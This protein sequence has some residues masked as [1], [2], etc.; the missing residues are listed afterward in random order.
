MNEYSLAKVQSIFIMINILLA[1]V[2]TKVLFRSFLVLVDSPTTLLNRMCSIWFT[3]S[4][5]SF[6]HNKFI[7]INKSLND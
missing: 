1:K 6:T 5:N 4:Q 7:T 2:S 3:S